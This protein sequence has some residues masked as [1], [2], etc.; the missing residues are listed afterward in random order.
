MK[1]LLSSKPMQAFTLALGNLPSRIS[2]LS[3]PG[4]SS[5]KNFSAWLTALKS[6]NARA[7]ASAPTASLYSADL[8]TAFDNIT[9]QRQTPAAALNAVADK[10][11]S[12]AP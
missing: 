4:Y 6:P 12:Y 2:L 8:A 9:Q 10:A 11:K 1:Y 7:I 3:D 5:L